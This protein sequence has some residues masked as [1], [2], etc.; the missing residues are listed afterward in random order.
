MTRLSRTQILEWL[1]SEPR[2]THSCLIFL[3][4]INMNLMFMVSLVLGLYVLIVV[5][6]LRS[7][8]RIGFYVCGFEYYLYCCN[9]SCGIAYYRY[10]RCLR[11]CCQD[12]VNMNLNLIFKVMFESQLQIV[13]WNEV[14][15]TQIPVI[16]LVTCKSTSEH[17][18]VVHRFMSNLGTFKCIIK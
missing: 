4:A 3:I 2:N 6:L 12:F 5:L 8:L 7:Y 11:W 1:H 13:D 9:P 16:M 17:G 18:V 10:E 15:E 14:V